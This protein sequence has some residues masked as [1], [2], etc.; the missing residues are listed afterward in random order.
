[1][2]RDHEGRSGGFFAALA[3]LG[4]LFWKIAWVSVPGA[5]RGYPRP[6]GVH[7][8]SLGDDG[9]RKVGCM[10]LSL[11][12]VSLTGIVSSIRIKERTQGTQI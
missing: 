12:L 5:L 2:R 9:L 11:S 6:Y 3:P 1:M 7:L 8:R 4:R 10:H